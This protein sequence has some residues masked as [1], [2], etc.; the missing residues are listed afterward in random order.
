VP[1]IHVYVTRPPEKD[2]LEAFEGLEDVV[3]RLEHVSEAKA[4]PTHS[5][6]AVT[7]EG[8]RAEKQEIKRA[9]EEVGYKVSRLSVRSEFPGGTY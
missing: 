9:I 5:V 1:D 7:F 2:V 3:K 8:G 4:D 6:V